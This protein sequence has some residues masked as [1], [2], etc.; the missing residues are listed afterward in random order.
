LAILAKSAIHYSDI[1]SNKELDISYVYLIQNPI[2]APHKLRKSMLGSFD[3]N[4]HVPT[5]FRARKVGC[6][7][8]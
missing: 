4:V 7:F 3:I 8:F 1:I 2:F 6:A 5:S